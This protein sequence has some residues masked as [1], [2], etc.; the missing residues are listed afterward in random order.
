MKKPK[1][2]EWY[3]F[4]TTS[5]YPDHRSCDCVIRAISL[6]T[7]KT[8]LEVFDD[9]TEMAREMYRIPNEEKVYIKYLEK[10]GWKKHNQP[11]KTDCD[12]YTAKEFT[13]VVRGTAILKLAHHL[14]C[15]KDG[16]LHDIWDCG[17]KCVG[18]YW[19]NE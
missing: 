14:V 7:G 9:L 16:K 15:V 19:T 8:W 4:D 11:W 6:A 3:T 17:G 1:E 5:K 10:I 2:T 13:N 12:K 18:V